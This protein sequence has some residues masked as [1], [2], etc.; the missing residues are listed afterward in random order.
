MGG[1]EAR[2][3]PEESVTGMIRVVA[4]LSLGDTGRFLGH[5]GREL[6]W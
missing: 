4:D 6:P 5:D 3:S 2:L 1:S